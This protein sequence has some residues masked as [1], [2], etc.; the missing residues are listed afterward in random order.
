M[1]IGILRSDKNS[2]RCPM[3]NCF[4][5]LAQRREGFEDYS[6]TELAGLFTL[7]PDLEEN[8]GLARILKAKGAEAIHVVT[9]AFA[10]KGEGG[11]VLGNGLENGLDETLE[12]MARDT[13]LPCVKGT[14]HLP[15]GYVP[16]RF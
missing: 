7:T 3:T 11:W 6:E 15:A 14:A 2:R 16:Q 13:G 12:R 5:C 9:C 8:L 1:K 10:H 4:K